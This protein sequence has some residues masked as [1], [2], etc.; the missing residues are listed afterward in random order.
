MSASQHADSLGSRRD[1]RGAGGPAALAL[2]A[3]LLCAQAPA[4][5]E[6]ARAVNLAARGNF[7]EAEQVLRALE[8]TQPTGFEV[9]YRLGVILL[10]QGKTDEAAIRFEAAV[11]LAPRSA[12]AWLGLAQTRLKLG[13]RQSALDIAGRAAGFGER[14]PPVWRA[15]ALF[16]SEAGEFARA[17]EFEERWSRSPGADRASAARVCRL[18][19]R[20]ADGKRSVDSCRRA[21]AGGES[22]ELQQLLGDA[23][24]LA[25]DP[26]RAVDA[27]QR[28][29]G[30]D[31]AQPGAYFQIVALF[32]DHRTP[33]P[34]IAMLESAIARFPT[35]PE[36]RRRLGLAHYQTGA[37][38]PAI[39]AF[40]SALDLEPDADAGYASLETLLPEV[41][42]R[43]G[44][45]IVRLLGFRARRPAS[46]VG[47]FLLARALALEG[48]SGKEVATLLRQAVQADGSFW[49]AH[50]ELAQMH[51]AE[52]RIEEVIRSLE[53]VVKL[54]PGYAP[55]HYNLAQHY[56][57]A[58]DRPRAVEHRK[59][60]HALLERER[61]AA[62]RGRA[63][64]PSLPFRID[65]PVR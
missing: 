23:Y 53:S 24:R 43:L 19:V 32:L 26:A 41:G 16:Y 52:G 37:I 17:A 38:Q 40:L 1:R 47:H 30:L 58:G 15:L 28:A 62:D 11:Q 12:L 25:G 54:N 27:Y 56:A 60:H 35:D 18:L 46:P 34:A 55:A 64:S 63:E 9:R 22:A 65:A 42:P 13:Q 36:F 50:F 21:L 2:A 20:A 48:D 49:P 5:N 3:S 29:I 61:A 59:T 4:S 39:D 51:G 10:R 6:L 45:I 7:P 57:Q 33:Q 31:P 44:E 8:K 14:E